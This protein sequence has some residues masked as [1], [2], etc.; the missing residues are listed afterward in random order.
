MTLRYT[1]LRRKD[2]SQVYIPNSRVL[3]QPVANYSRRKARLL[4]VTIKLKNGT[5]VAIIR[6]ALRRLETQLQILHPDVLSHY[7]HSAG[8]EKTG[9]VPVKADQPKAQFF[10]GLGKLCMSRPP[11]T[12]PFVASWMEILLVMTVSGNSLGEE[13]FLKVKTEMLLRAREILEELQIEVVD[14][15]SK[16]RMVDVNRVSFSSLQSS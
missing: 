16:S 9:S 13:G 4:E 12:D 5:S 7:N 3:E 14:E 8:A 2:N 11:L 6:E 1:N 10:A 15:T